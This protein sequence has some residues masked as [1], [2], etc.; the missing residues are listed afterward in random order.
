MWVLVGV[1]KEDRWK[2]KGT[3]QERNSKGN[4]TSWLCTKRWTLCICLVEP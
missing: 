3:G 2:E 4:T 1:R